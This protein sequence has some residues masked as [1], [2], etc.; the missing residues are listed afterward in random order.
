MASENGNSKAEK[1]EE[2]LRQK[3]KT[4][5]V[6][7]SEMRILLS[8]PLLNGKVKDNTNSSGSH[9]WMVSVTEKAIQQFWG[10][11]SFNV[12]MHNKQIKPVYVDDVLKYLAFIK[13]YNTP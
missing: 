8:H 1:L 7:E 13:E 5:A 2:K 6:S 3:S 4:V 9:F 11:S 12:V 10:H